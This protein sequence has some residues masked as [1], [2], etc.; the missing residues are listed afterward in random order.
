MMFLLLDR[1]ENFAKL[2]NHPYVLSINYIF[3]FLLK[4]VS[5]PKV[6]RQIWAIFFFFYSQLP[7]HFF[8]WGQIYE[9]QHF[10]ATRLHSS[11]NQSSFLCNQLVR[12]S[13]TASLGL[14]GGGHPD[15]GLPVCTFCCQGSSQTYACSTSSSYYQSSLCTN[16]SHARY[17]QLNK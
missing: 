3:T 5:S 9:F 13:G 16:N 1:N 6:W 14:L 7:S 10:P 15:H 8:C 2:N 17:R 11:A 4:K 12:L